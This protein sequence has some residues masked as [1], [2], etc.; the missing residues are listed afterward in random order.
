[1]IAN[2][3][4]LSVS[5]YPNQLEVGIIKPR[6]V[7]QQNGQSIFTNLSNE[8]L[9]P[10]AHYTVCRQFL[11]RKW[12]EGFCLPLFCLV[13]CKPW[14]GVAAHSCNLCTWEAEV[15]G[16][17]IQGRRHYHHPTNDKQKL[18]P[19]PHTHT[20][21]NL[22]SLAC[23]VAEVRE[24]PWVGVSNRH[25]TLR[26]PVAD[27]QLLCLKIWR[28]WLVAAKPNS[29]TYLPSLSI[30]AVQQRNELL[31]LVVRKFSSWK[32]STLKYQITVFTYLIFF[33]LR[34]HS[35]SIHLLPTFFWVIFHHE[36]CFIG[37]AN[38]LP[39]EITVL[40][41][42]ISLPGNS[43]LAASASSLSSLN[44]NQGSVLGLGKLSLIAFL[45]WVM[46]RV[47][48]CWWTDWE[49]PNEEKSFP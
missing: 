44:L 10:V 48:F 33:Q 27:I 40:L 18:S 36:P 25:P 13:S 2:H 5:K 30:R 37:E 7:I 14:T 21:K 34:S 43:T 49:K 35:N 47:L 12:R 46:A 23:G 1:M 4:P 28:H 41:F 16:S 38:S 26:A 6:K 9:G 42:T 8:D 19:Y 11:E 15:R 3:S 22:I 39:S 17:Q 20:P 29:D 32:I 45:S 31:V 24:V